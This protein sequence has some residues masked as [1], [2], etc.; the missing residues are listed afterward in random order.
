L[1]IYFENT[2]PSASRFSNAIGP[3]T[4]ARA[5]IAARLGLEARLARLSDDGATAL[6]H[7]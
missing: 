4:P 5:A 6:D 2:H 1:W 3:G 7:R